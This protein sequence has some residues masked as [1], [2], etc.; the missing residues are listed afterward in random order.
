M[1]EIQILNS[2]QVYGF[3]DYLQKQ[4]TNKFMNKI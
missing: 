3:K 2:F 1:V 4:V